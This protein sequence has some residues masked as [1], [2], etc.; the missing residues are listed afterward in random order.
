MNANLYKIRADQTE[1]EL[2]VRTE[3]YEYQRQ[4]A[5]HLQAER[6]ALLP[7]AALLDRVL[8]VPVILEPATV[9]SAGCK[10]RTVVI[11]LAAGYR[12]KPAAIDAAREEKK[13]Q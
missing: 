9:I 4:R 12:S 6:D 1:A 3:N 10:I 5:D 2:S 8:T 13:I 11:G 7:D